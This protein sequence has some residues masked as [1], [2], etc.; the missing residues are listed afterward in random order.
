MRAPWDASTFWKWCHDCEKSVIEADW[1]A[2]LR[3]HIDRPEDGALTPSEL[4]KVLGI[5]VRTVRWRMAHGHI[6]HFTTAAA[7]RRRFWV[8]RAELKRVVD[9]MANKAAATMLKSVG[10]R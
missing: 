4:A 5:P 1:Q 2:H 10:L 6:R 8:T 7:G 3:G 9:E